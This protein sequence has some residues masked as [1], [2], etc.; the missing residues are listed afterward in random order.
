MVAFF[1]LVGFEIRREMAGGEL[2]SW[3]NAMAPLAAALGGMLVPALV[4]A[5]MVHGGQGSRGWGIPMATDVAFALGALALVSTGASTRMRVFLL[6]L[7]V[8][9]DIRD[10]RV[11]VASTRDVGPAAGGRAVSP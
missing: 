3:R 10:R 1:V 4:Y 8:A 5:L 7:A 11:L 6:T 2:R 9:D